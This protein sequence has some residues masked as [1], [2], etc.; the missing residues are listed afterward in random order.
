[1]AKCKSCGADL[2]EDARYCFRCGKPVAGVSEEF[3]VSAED[4]VK[5]I[6]ELVHEG[7]ITRII[8][9]D[10][11]GST[12]IEIPVTAGIIGALLAPWLAALGAVAAFVTKCTIIV[13]KRE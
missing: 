1:M 5:K 4:L 7:N 10:E 11:K 9:K 3:S 12:L 8:V 2:P 13:E 6:K